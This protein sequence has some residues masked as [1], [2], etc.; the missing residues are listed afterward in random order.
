MNNQSHMSYSFCLLKD[1]CRVY[2][3]TKQNKI[4]IEEIFNGAI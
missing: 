4:N 3:I 1:S 2:V